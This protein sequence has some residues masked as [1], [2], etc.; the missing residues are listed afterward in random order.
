MAKS[1]NNILTDSYSG[2]L[3][4]IILHRDG[5]MRSIPDMSKRILSGG[6]LEHIKRFERAKEYGRQ[7][8]A[9]P[10]RREYYAGPLRKR[11]KKNPYIGIYQLAIMDFMNPPEVL[12]IFLESTGGNPGLTVIINV[13]DKVR[14][15]GADVRILSAEGNTIED[16]DAVELFLSQMFRYVVKDPL[17]LVKGSVIRVRVWDMPGNVTEKD[18]VYDFH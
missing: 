10:A 11:K 18:L 8:A 16:G 12:N 15:A 4:D 3:G 7:V 5:V 2:K 14:V 6:Q 1:R 13:T 17:L 9:D